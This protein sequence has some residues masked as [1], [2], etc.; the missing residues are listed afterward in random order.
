MLIKQVL[1]IVKDLRGG[2]WTG[3]LSSVVFFG[4]IYVIVILSGGTE[5]FVPPPH[6][7]WGLPN[8]LYDSPGLVRPVDCETQ[9]Y[10]GSPTQSMKTWEDR[11]QP[12]PKDRWIL[13]KSRPELLM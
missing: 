7:G 2:S 10:A 9:L 13:V 1:K 12:N 4:L 11:N 8:N 3:I 6:P 5:C